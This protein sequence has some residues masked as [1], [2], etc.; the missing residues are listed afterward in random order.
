MAQVVQL[1]TFDLKDPG[2]I[3]IGGLAFS[4]TFFVTHSE[5]RKHLFE[6]SQFIMLHLHERHVS[7]MIGREE[8]SLFPGNLSIKGRM[9]YSWT[10][11]VGRGNLPLPSIFV[12]LPSRKWF[13]KDLSE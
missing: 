8:I 1:W 13:G 5:L 6:E 12:I 10:K 7:E 9:L 11:I 2:S 4:S 3:A